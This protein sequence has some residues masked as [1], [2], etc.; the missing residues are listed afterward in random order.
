MALREYLVA[1]DKKE[2]ALSVDIVV[3]DGIAEITLNRPEALNAIDADM[4]AGLQEAWRRVK[5]DDE[6]R[7]AIV[8][9]AGGRAFCAGA[10]LKRTF[11][12]SEGFA[13][14]T[15]GSS[16]SGHLLAEMTMDKPIVCAING[17]A[18]G[19]G[20]EMALAC[21][22]RIASTNAELGLAEVKHGTIPG[23]GGTQN[24]PRAVPPSLAMQ[25]LLTGERIDAEKA[26]SS[27]LVSEIMLPEELLPRARQIA[28]RIAENGPLAVRAIKRAVREGLGLPLATALQLELFV[29]GS[30]RDTE[31]RIEGRRAFSEGRRPEFRGR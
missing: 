13:E 5:S 10:D 26:L 14:L 25:M 8:T 3:S 31:D 15:F 7:V 6:V 21:D 11:P 27:G 19:G 18:I 24:L 23:G 20:L 17:Y 9:G 28:G 12:P 16:P 30:L 2:T 1:S 22:I 29:W 4:R